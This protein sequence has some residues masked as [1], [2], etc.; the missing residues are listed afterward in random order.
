M[1]AGYDVTLIA[2]HERDEVVN[3]VRIMGL[4][5]PRN[6]FARIF[7][8]TWQAFRLALH[9]HA[10]IYH[11]HDPEF[12][13]WGWLLQK[14]SHRPVIY[15]VHEYYADS[16]RMKNWLP[17]AS[18]GILASIFD[19]FERTIARRLAGVVV[20]NQHMGKQFSDHGCNVEVLPN[21]PLKELFED[22]SSTAYLEQA[23]ENNQVLIYVGGL[24]E[25]RGI[26]RAIR[27]MRYLRKEFPQVKLLLLGKFESDLYQQG[28]VQLIE[29]LKLADNVD[30]LGHL[31]HPEVIRYL[32]VADIGIFLLQPV[33]ERYNWGEPIKYFEYSAAGLPVIISDL[34]AKRRL[35][36]KNQNG[37]LVDPLDE[38]EIA[39]SIASLLRDPQRMK[40]IGKRG[41]DAFLREY[42]WEA[43]E[44]RLVDLYKKLIGES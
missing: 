12:L 28:V 18:R 35:I 30:I 1:K 27:V 20:V 2:Q 23:Y 31:P 21:Y 44:K 8:L 24:S 38:E 16:I 42:N 13:P 10:D 3:G 40:E 7:G 19:F 17:R 37:I 15:D 11:F 33:N 41:R 4:R 9:Q 22:I 36:E 34:A 14:I 6:R 5:K 32:A 43:I 26:T 39:E 29:R 25:S